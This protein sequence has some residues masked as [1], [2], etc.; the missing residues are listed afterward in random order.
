MAVNTSPVFISTPVVTVTKI[1]V[2]QAIVASDGS[3]AGNNA[4]GSM[5]KIFTANATNGSWVDKIRVIPYGTTANTTITQ[6][7]IRVFLSSENQ[8]GTNATTNA[9]TAL[10]EEIQISASPVADGAVAA[11]NYYDIP[12]FIP[13]GPGRYLH[14]CQTIV[15]V[16]NTGWQIIV[17]GGDY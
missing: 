2:T 3:S 8:L 5:V 15:P 11:T 9:N 4:I 17:I 10:L 13:I 14:A 6:T 1:P 12:V 7:L 16:A